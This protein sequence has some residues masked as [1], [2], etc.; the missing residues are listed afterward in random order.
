ME[1]SP[2]EHFYPEFR[3]CAFE[4]LQYFGL[5]GWFFPDEFSLLVRHDTFP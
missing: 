2:R 1:R 4:F 5:F 3:P